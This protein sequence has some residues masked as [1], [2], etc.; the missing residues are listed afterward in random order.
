[1]FPSAIRAEFVPNFHVKEVAKDDKAIFAAPPGRGDEIL[2][3][4]MSY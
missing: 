3:K 2:D 4:K 1:L